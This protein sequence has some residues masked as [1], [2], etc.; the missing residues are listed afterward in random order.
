MVVGKKTTQLY[1]IMDFARVVQLFE[2]KE[3]YFANPSTWDDPYEQL[4]KHSKDHAVFGQCWSSTHTSDAL[5][6]IYSKD[7]MGVRIST[8]I[9]KFREI[10]RVGIQGKGYKYRLRQ[11]EYVSQIRLNNK[12]KYVAASLRTVFN[13]GGAVDMLYV[14]R[15]AFE[16]ED[17]WRATLYCP[18]EIKADGKKGITIPVD[19]HRFIKSILLDP[20][21]SDELV[22]AFT[23]YFKSKLGFKGK[24]A[25]SVLYKKPKG[26]EIEDD[27]LSIE[28]L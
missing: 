5:W 24:V 18:S 6:R 8:S 17:E 9:E 27:V 19:P 20:R 11:V 13:I 16:H 15:E 14:K 26:Y 21:A 25:R 7:G 2:K 23:F 28:D 3:L 10:I 22:D 4:I 12:A 1:R